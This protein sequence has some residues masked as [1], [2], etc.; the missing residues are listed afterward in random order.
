MDTNQPIAN[1][2]A[3]A[4]NPYSCPVEVTLEAI[5]GKW[6]C[7]ILWWLQQGA[8]RFGELRLLMPGMSQKVLSDQL[9]ELEADGLVHRTAYRE[10]PPRVEYALTPRGQTLTPITDLMCRWGKD[11]L[12]GFEAGRLRFEG[13]H[14][15]VVCHQAELSAGLVAQLGAA[16]GAQVTL[17]SLAEALHHLHRL[18]PDVVLAAPDQGDWRSLTQRL[19]QGPSPIPAIALV[20]SAQQRSWAFTQGFRLVLGIPIDPAE[21]AAAI[22]SLTGWLHRRSSLF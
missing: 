6:K 15:A 12:Q 17:L 18:H 9:R 3:K 4:A 20:P 5:G 13:L 7:V 16:R 1:P 2:A 8:R 19:A 10:K 21:L 11:Q 14:I 22:A